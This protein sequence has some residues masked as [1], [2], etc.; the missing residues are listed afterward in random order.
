MDEV[1]TIQE[2]ELRFES[3]WVLVG[4]PVM[5]A[6]NHV[7]SGHVLAHSPDRDELYR[8]GIALKPHRSAI[9][10]TGSIPE[11]TAVVL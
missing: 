10:F 7:L 1:M 5:D 4:D 9:L 3:E 6:G 8:R 2:I 11:N